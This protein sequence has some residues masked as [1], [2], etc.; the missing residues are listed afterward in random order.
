MGLIINVD[1]IEKI[2]I[3]KTRQATYVRHIEDEPEKR[4][5]FGCIK[6]K[7]VK[8]HWWDYYGKYDTR[9]DLINSDCSKKYY[10]NNDVLYENSIWE[11]DS[12]YIIISHNNTITLYF[13]TYEELTQKVNDMVVQSNNNLMVINE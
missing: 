13:D 7:E 1:K 12:I 5:F 3:I 6:Q 2:Y 9:E 11:K 10:I 4:G 8:A